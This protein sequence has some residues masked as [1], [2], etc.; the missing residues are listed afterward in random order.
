MPVFLVGDSE[1][2]AV[3]VIRQLEKWHWNYV[4]RQK[5]NH[6]VKLASNNTWLVTPEFEFI[7]FDGTSIE[8]AYIAFNGA[9]STKLGAFSD[10]DI[11]YFLLK[12]FF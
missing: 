11:V 6:Q 10:S 9:T 8:I 5:A 12:A 2:G 4:L 1:F 3:P 7:P